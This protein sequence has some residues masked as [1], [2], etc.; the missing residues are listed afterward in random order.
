[1]AEGWEPQ[2]QGALRGR[3]DA[4]RPG[5]PGPGPR[6]YRRAVAGARDRRRARR[7]SCP[8]WSSRPRSRRSTASATSS[9]AWPTPRSASP[10]R[11]A[12]VRRPGV[13]MRSHRPRH[14]RW[15]AA[16][17]PHAR[18]RPRRPPAPLTNLAHLDFL[19]RTRRAA[20]AGRAHHLPAGRRARASACCGCTPTARPA[21][22]TSRPAAATYDAATDTYG[23]GAYDADDISRAAVVYLRHWRRSGDGT[24][25]TQAYQ[26]LRGLTYLQTT[27]GA[28]RRQRGAVDA[29]RRH[30]QPEP[31]PAGRP[32]PVRLRRRRTGWPARSGR[33]ARGTPRSGTA[34]PAFAAFLRGPPGPGRRRARPRGARALRQVPD[35]ARRE[36]ARLA[37]R[38]RRRRQRRRRCSA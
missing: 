14:R 4:A 38:R 29:A 32:D 12:G 19:D 31:D 21:A 28:A 10:T 9:T 24:A 17:S 5:R 7:A 37:D 6:P 13:T 34:D 36:G 27:T 20:R 11:P 22:A 18:R 1:M 2:Q 35:R 33:S 25:A 26:L 16:W 8:T 23:Q 15:R 3:R 30:A